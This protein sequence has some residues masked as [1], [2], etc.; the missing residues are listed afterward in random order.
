VVALWDLEQAR[1]QVGREQRGHL[2]LEGCVW[3]SAQIATLCEDDEPARGG[4]GIVSMMLFERKIVLFS[5]WS[6]VSLR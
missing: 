5:A 6:R 3:H 1:E 2:Y 4:V